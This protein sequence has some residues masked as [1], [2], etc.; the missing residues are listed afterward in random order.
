MPIRI[1]VFFYQSKR[2]I[3]QRNTDRYRPILFCLVLNVLYRAINYVAI[4]HLEI[5]GSLLASSGLTDLCCIIA[6]G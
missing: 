4:G 2:S 1:P 3:I 5:I 6:T